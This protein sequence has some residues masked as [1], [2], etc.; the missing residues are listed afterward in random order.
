MHLTDHLSPVT[1]RQRRTKR[2]CCTTHALQSQGE[3]RTAQSRSVGHLQQDGVSGS[4][5]KESRQGHLLSPYVGRLVP[6]RKLNPPPCAILSPTNGSNRARVASLRF[7]PTS[8][9]AL[10]Q[11]RGARRWS[12]HHGC[13]PE[14]GLACS[15]HTSSSF[16]RAAVTKF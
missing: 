15:L 5:P 13:R 8:V 16:Q 10:R 1:R 7:R 12:K 2:T 6:V 9:K 11:S 3:R 4:K 14:V